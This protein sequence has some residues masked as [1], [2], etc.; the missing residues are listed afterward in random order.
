MRVRG[1][2]LRRQAA[3]RGWDQRTLARHAQVSEATVSRAMAG[4]CV[5]GRTALLLVQ[6]LRRQRPVPELELLLAQ[7]ADEVRRSANP[8]SR[9]RGRRKQP[10]A[11]RTHSADSSTDQLSR[12]ASRP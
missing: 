7:P 10:S 1:A 6:A 11:R 3:I 4:E 8:R 5:R 12:T 2:A 9:N